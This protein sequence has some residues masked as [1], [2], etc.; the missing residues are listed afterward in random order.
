MVRVKNYAS[1]IKHY[2][3]IFSCT[4]TIRLIIMNVNIPLCNSHQ[5]RKLCK[6]VCGYLYIRTLRMMIINGVE[7]L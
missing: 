6:Q 5:G 2:I 1:R 7:K 3:F 4:E